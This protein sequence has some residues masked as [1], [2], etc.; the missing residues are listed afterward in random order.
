MS[1]I[2]SHDHR[3]LVDH[4]PVVE[5]ITRVS[6]ES[7]RSSVSTISK[8]PS[9]SSSAETL[10]EE[11]GLLIQTHRR[12]RHSGQRAKVKV[13]VCMLGK[14]G[15]S[16]EFSVT[17]SSDETLDVLRQRIARRISASLVV[18]VR[19]TSLGTANGGSGGGGGE[20]SA[21][22]NALLDLYLVHSTA[23]PDHSSSGLLRR[24]SSTFRWTPRDSDTTTQRHPDDSKRTLQ[25]DQMQ[26][27]AELAASASSF[28]PSRVITALPFC[29]LMDE[30][31]DLACVVLS[32]KRCLILAAISSERLAHY[33][34][35]LNN[36]GFHGV[37]ACTSARNSLD[38]YGIYS[39]ISLDRRTMD[40]AN[41]ADAQADGDAS[42]ILAINQID[43]AMS[44]G[45]DSNDTTDQTI[46]TN[47]TT[48][49][50]AATPATTADSS[51]PTTSNGSTFGIFRKK[52]RGFRGG[53]QS[54]M[55][56]S[57]LTQL[58]N[59]NSPRPA[60]PTIAQ[61][62]TSSTTHAIHSSSLP[63][64]ARDGREHLH[65]QT[66]VGRSVAP[67]VV[68]M[69]ALSLEGIPL[70]SHAQRAQVVLDNL[71]KKSQSAS[72]QN[73]TFSAASI[74][75]NPNDPT[76]ITSEVI[77]SVLV[78][79]VVA[80]RTTTT[81]QVPLAKLDDYLAAYTTTEQRA[82][83]TATVISGPALSTGDRM[84]TMQDPF[85]GGAPPSGASTSTATILETP[86]DSTVEEV[87]TTDPDVVGSPAPPSC[88]TNTGSA[89]P[90]SIVIAGKP[91]V[92][93]TELLSSITM[94][95]AGTGGTGTG[96]G[97]NGYANNGGIS[98][99][100]GTGVPVGPK[101]L[102]TG[103]G[104]S[105][106][107]RGA[108]VACVRPLASSGPLTSAE[109]SPSPFS[110]MEETTAGS[111]GLPGD[112][113][114]RFSTNRRFVIDDDVREYA[115]RTSI[116]GAG[117]VAGSGTFGMMRMGHGDGNRGD[118]SR[119]SALRVLAA[120]DASVVAGGRRELAATKGG[121]SSSEEVTQKAERG[122]KRKGKSGAGRKGGGG[123][124]CFA[125]VKKM[126]GR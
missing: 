101:E 62:P 55:S 32:A 35:T 34:A 100:R 119:G 20:L 120:A 4:A 48:I 76:L 13:S 94:G 107:G 47:V 65:H 2:A 54:P 87:K 11:G 86:I 45:P 39:R 63:T 72:S 30:R 110:L 118:S 83:M 126:F 41:S 40:S 38:R 31:F 28:E 112:V 44:S 84:T 43:S 79:S 109:S 26:R 108:D 16:P 85:Y 99:T 21:T 5:Y 70:E 88:L 82:F 19:G 60:S 29:T 22:E 106:S 52:S 1:A 51:A 3:S 50:S 93:A 104:L 121:D 66:Q 7:H 105:L 61:P 92:A 10:H 46:S 9:L 80:T 103:T 17:A 15:L 115:R 97:T 95:V 14:P 8:A 57:I 124:G 24:A 49:A 114:T 96:M 68:S 125:F 33:R 123:T 18:R 67:N 74:A 36:L 25:P 89:A 6:I 116:G 111:M 102:S 91:G 12:D 113:G 117:A 71:A 69:R 27:I 122:Y 53:G 98:V 78:S 58:K 81:L 75:G 59:S 42:S 77:P 23:T 73:S 64:G 56:P 90:T 37:E